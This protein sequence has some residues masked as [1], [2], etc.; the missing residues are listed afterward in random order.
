MFSERIFE[1]ILVK[2]PELIEDKLRF[3]GRQ[4]THF[5]KRIDIL[6]EDRFNEKLIIELK[7][8]NLDRNALSQ[9]MEYEGYILSEKD[10]SARVM[11]IANRIPLNLK[12]AMNHHGIEYKEIT[13]KQILE[14]LEKNDHQ[15][16]TQITSPFQQQTEQPQMMIS[17][18]VPNSSKI[19][20]ASKLDEILHAGGYWDEL[21]AKAEIESKKLDGHIKYSKGV[22]D[23]HIRYRTITQKNSEY[24]RN[25]IIT[26]TGIFPKNQISESH[27]K[28]IIG[29]VTNV[30]A[31]KDAKDR[32]EIW[33]NRSL[34]DCFPY[35]QTSNPE[36][37]EIKIKLGNMIYP[38]GFH[39]TSTCIWL[40]A[41]LDRDGYNLTDLLK[42]QGIDNREKL[43][44]TSIGDKLYE[45]TRLNR[46]ADLSR[47]SN[48]SSNYITSRRGKIIELINQG[49]S[50]FEILES[51]DKIFPPGHFATSNKQAIYGTR[52]DLRL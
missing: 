17:K 52:R 14:F 24:L 10:P 18:I 37:I 16:F 8:D 34:E 5:G 22:L 29:T 38:I 49:L 47:Y 25:Y 15:L 36:G 32:F 48:N 6:F 26:Q 9:V 33:F 4:V 42:S 41:R 12:K 51:I 30:K 39:N 2:Y 31:K 1:D 40:S 11:L 28:K 3:V 23:A 43:A 44:L 35:G 19:T 7:K 20:M 46:I 27:S 21:I 50:D 45:I 13:N